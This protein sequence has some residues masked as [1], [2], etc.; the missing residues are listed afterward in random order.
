MSQ[1]PAQHQILYVFAIIFGAHLDLTPTQ[2]IE[3]WDPNLYIMYPSSP[4]P[5][6][7][8]ILELIS[9]SLGAPLDFVPSQEVK[10]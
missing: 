10:P 5:S 9:K 6:Q 2:K 8:Q 7:H 4:Y 3:A 1:Y